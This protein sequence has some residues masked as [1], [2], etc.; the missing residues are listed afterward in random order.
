MSLCK[1]LIVT[2]IAVALT[3]PAMGAN[4]LNKELAM[5]VQQAAMTSTRPSKVDAP[6]GEDSVRPF[7][8]NVPD[9]DLADLER[10]LAATRWPTQETRQGSVAGRAA[11]TLK[12][13]VRYWATDYDWR[14]AEARLNAYPQFMTK[15]DGVDIHFIHVRSRH[16]NAMPMIITHGWPGSVIELLEVID[17]LTIRPRTAA[18][19]PTP[20]M[21]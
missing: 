10:R 9:A 14:K 19:P 18:R 15:I 13:L 16:P 21:S 3:S 8:V 7:R 2:S 20:S 1:Q 6:R 11:G 4:E 12:E 5:T 17:P